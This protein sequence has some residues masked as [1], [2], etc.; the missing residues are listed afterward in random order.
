MSPLINKS[1]N[2]LLVLF[3]KTCDE[4]RPFNIHRY[5]GCIQVER[6]ICFFSTLFGKY[7]LLH[8]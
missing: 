7:S 8:G 3:E 1:V 6:V 5:T 2:D 4:G